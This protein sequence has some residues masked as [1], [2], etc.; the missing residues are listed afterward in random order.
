MIA[1][2]LAVMFAVGVQSTFAFT[3][4]AATATETETTEIEVAEEIEQIETYAATPTARDFLLSGHSYD[5]TPASEFN[6]KP[7][8]GAYDLSKVQ[9]GDIIYDE[10]DNSPE[11]GHAAIVSN[12]AHNSDYGTYIQTI[13]VMPD[14]GV[15]YGFLDDQR[16]YEFSSSAC[17][18]YLSNAQQRLD[19]IA[20]CKSQ[21]GKGYWYDT[22][23]SPIDSDVNQPDWYSSELVYAAYQVG[24]GRG[25]MTGSSDDHHILP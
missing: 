15:T 11:G 4:K 13:E 6:R 2:A 10:W 14:R 18:V 5:K 16:I 3:A 8:Y 9:V 7:I 19:A 21:L 17:Y 23:N 1:I 20:F 25:L 12:I 24:M 22:D